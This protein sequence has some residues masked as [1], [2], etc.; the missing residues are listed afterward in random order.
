[1]YIG[2]LAQ[3]LAECEACTQ[4]G[5]K[6]RLS[7]TA[8]STA[9]TC[10][11][12]WAN[13]TVMN[14]QSFSTNGSRFVD[15]LPTELSK[16]GQ[17]HGTWKTISSI[18]AQRGGQKRPKGRCE[19]G[20]LFWR[21]ESKAFSFQRFPNCLD[22]LDCIFMDFLGCFGFW[23]QRMPA[24]LFPLSISLHVTAFLQVPEF[25]DLWSDTR[26][27][28]VRL[29]GYHVVGPLSHCKSEFQRFYVIFRFFSLHFLHVELKTAAISSKSLH[30]HDA[31]HYLYDL[32]SLIH[33][34]W[35]IKNLHFVS[36]KMPEI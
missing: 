1:M 12:Q 2:Q 17:G 27:A 30:G 33:W 24:K 35:L 34:S 6:D 36:P 10:F 25:M 9:P 15:C 11:V 22:S 14:S 16:S 29:T 26:F 7:H 31:M 13:W 21:Q 19:F 20:P 28:S 4:P 32:G 8:S 3:C 18:E 5:Q 23:G